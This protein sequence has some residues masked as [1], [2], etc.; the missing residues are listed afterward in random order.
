MPQIV[1]CPICHS[2]KTKFLF[3]GYDHWF[4]HPDSSLVYSCKECGHVFVAG[5]LTPEQLT[6]MYTNYYPRSNFNVEDYQPYKEKSGFLY[7]LDG[8]E[9]LAHNHVPKN[10]RVLDIGCGYC[11]TLGYHKNRGCEAY[12]VEAD[13]NAKQ[14]ADKY[15]FSIKTGLFDPK[16]YEQNFFDY[17][18]MSYVLEHAVS[19][20]A[21]LKDIHS[22][23]R[24]GGYLIATV[25]NLRAFGRYFFGKLWVNW[26]FP[27][28]RHF[29]SKQ[30]ISILAEQS[31]FLVNEMRSA[32]ESR[33][34]LA[35]WSNL[36]CHIISD[37]S[38]VDA[39]HSFEKFDSEMKKLWLVSL[40]MFLRKIRFWTIPMRLA[41]MF[42]CGDCNLIVLQKK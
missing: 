7:W 36:F 2:E 30:S 21:M 23:I 31:Q 28:H 37:K 39:S 29:Y 32:T 11:E 10:V 25:P 14:I 20:L 19:P 17:V 12:G 16:D 4:G 18:T 9:G 5:E 8:E 26:H 22:V 35:N 1:T 42:G 15:G 3:E 38:V 24:P 41:D 34:L 40:Y 13:E 27:Y 33:Y 6:D